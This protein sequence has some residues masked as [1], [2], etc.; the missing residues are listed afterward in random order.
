MLDGLDHVEEL[1]NRFLGP[2]WYRN[3]LSHSHAT[4]STLMTAL[5]LAEVA[6]AVNTVPSLNA[7]LDTFLWVQY[8]HLIPLMHSATTFL[9]RVRLRFGLDPTD[10]FWRCD[11]V[12]LT[13]YIIG[14]CTFSTIFNYEM[15]K[16]LAAHR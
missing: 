5:C 13:S 16:K 2:A 6:M 14:S 11:A 8:C 12:P 1:T 4:L 7:T 3:N 10:R 9:C 15:F